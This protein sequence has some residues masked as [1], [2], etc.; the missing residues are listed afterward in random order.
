MPLATDTN[1]TRRE[2]EWS[3]NMSNGCERNLKI[4]AAVSKHRCMVIFDECIFP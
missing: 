4:A 1:G 2:N 3:K